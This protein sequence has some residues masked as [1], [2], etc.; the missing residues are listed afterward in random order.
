[1]KA[2]A[3]LAGK[4]AR[5]NLR[6]SVEAD[7]TIRKAAALSGQDVTSFMVSCALDR[8]RAVIAEESI[9][10]LSSTD[11]EALVAVIE[12]G[13]EPVGQLVELLQRAARNQ[14]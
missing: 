8:A 4:A 9:I 14:G 2:S 12:Q 10:R 11:A 1:M 13:E 7:L 6:V 5:L 3:Q